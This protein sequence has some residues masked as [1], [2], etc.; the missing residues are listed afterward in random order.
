MVDLSLLTDL[1][2]G[3]HLGQDEVPLHNEDLLYTD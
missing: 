1:L 2:R 3:E